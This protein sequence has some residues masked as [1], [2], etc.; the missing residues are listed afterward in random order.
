MSI[1]YSGYPMIGVKYV[2]NNRYRIQKPEILLFTKKGIS[3]NDITAEYPCIHPINPIISK[4]LIVTTL[5]V[6]TVQIYT[7]FS[8]NPNFRERKSG[9]SHEPPLRPKNR[10]M[11]LDY[12]HYYLIY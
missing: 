2:Q 8:E 9:Y 1:R 5:L 7:K 12:S 3:I 4:V 11:I 10:Y 6:Y